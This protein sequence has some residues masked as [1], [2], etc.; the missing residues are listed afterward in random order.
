M[1]TSLLVAGCVSYSPAPQPSS[2][3]VTATTTDETTPSPTPTRRSGR[4]FSSGLNKQGQLGRPADDGTAIELA[5]VALPDDARVVAVAGGGR[6]TLAV[7]ADGHVMSWGANDFGQLGRPASSGEIAEVSA[8]DGAPGVL[9]DVVAVAADTDFSMAL[10]GDG[11]VVTWGK[12]DAGQRGTGML[13]APLQPTVVQ[14]PGGAEPL[15]EVVAIAADGRSELALLEDGTVLGWGANRYGML[16]DGTREDRLLPVH[17]KSPDGTSSLSGVSSVA[18]GGQ[19]A[20]A[21]LTTGEVFAWGRNDEGQLGDG[22]GVDRPL[23]GPVRDVG[24]GAQLTRVVQVAAAEKHSFALRSDGTVVAW[25]DNA[26]GQ[27]GDGTVRDRNVP[28]P[29]VNSGAGPVLKGVAEVFAGEA[30]G[31][32]ILDDATVRTWGAN[33]NGQLGAGDR[34][35]RNR[36]GPVVAASGERLSGVLTVAAG[37]RHLLLLAG[38][39]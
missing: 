22:T 7:L 26:G 13:E 12:G 3:T 10:R 15:A 30:Y 17:V 27:L 18:I 5:P 29:V 14:A 11:T 28:V 39:G 38:G 2:S 34:S 9:E 32:V 16:G 8:P 23:P 4:L 19:H 31:V 36:P 6:H 33:G 35:P 1:L 37:E 20:V 24:G 25:G 21:V